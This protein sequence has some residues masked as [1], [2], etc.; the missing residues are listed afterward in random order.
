VGEYRL[1]PAAKNDIIDIWNYTVE[2]WGAGQAEK[3]LLYIESQ[4][5]RLADN[6]DLGKHRPEIREGYYSFPVK[7]HIVFYL[8]AKQHIQI[9]GVLHG[10]MDVDARL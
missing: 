2:S 6:P 1:T 7:K 3:Y 5:D 8:K 4:L 10:R 9:I